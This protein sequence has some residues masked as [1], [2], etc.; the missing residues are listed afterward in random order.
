M[1]EYVEYT[2]RCPKCVS[3]WIR[4]DAQYTKYVNDIQRMRCNKCGK[5]FLFHDTREKFKFYIWI[6]F[7][8]IQTHSLKKTAEKLGV[9][10]ST[11]SKHIIPARGI[12]A[13]ICRLGIFTALFFYDGFADL[14]K[15]KYSIP[16]T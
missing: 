16:S 9:H 4:K 13:P 10:T 6:T 15:Q 3:A 1:D 11:V 5:R 2:I 8:M 14:S 7:F 12:A